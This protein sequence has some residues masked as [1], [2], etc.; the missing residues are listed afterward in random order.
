MKTAVVELQTY[1]DVPTL[2]DKLLWARAPRILLVWP[3]VGRPRLRGPLDFVLLRRYAARLGARLAVVTRDAEVAAWARQARVAVFPDVEAA[4]R[5]AW[6][7]PRRRPRRPARRA[8]PGAGPRARP[9]APGRLTRW[10]AALA[11]VGAVLALLAF[12]LPRAR[13]ELPV[14]AR[15]QQ[16]TLT[17]WARPGGGEGALP[18]QEVQVTVAGEYRRA[19]QGT[20]LWPAQSATGR[21]VFTNLGVDAVDIPAGLRITTVAEPRVTFEVTRGGRVPAGVG[22][23]TTL[24]VRALR[25]GAVGNRPADDLRVLPA[26]WDLRVTVTNPEPTQGGADL[27]VPWP[28][29]DEYAALRRAAETDLRTQAAAR[30]RARGWPWVPA[31]LRVAETVQAVFTPAQPAAAAELYLRL[32]QRYRAWALDPATL[33]AWLTAA[34][35]ARLEPGWQ[36]RAGTLTWTLARAEPA[37]Q[38]EGWAWTVHAVRQVHRSPAPEQVAAW[39]RGRPPRAAQA[40]L[41]ARLALREPPRVQVWPSFWP[42]L[43]WWEA[44]VQVVVVPPAGEGPAGR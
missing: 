3:Q 31:S 6:R 33:R 17:V 36:A 16:A 40:A 21:V 15:P 37:P 14:P 8:K 35:D 9:T 13:V 4:Q 28:E 23:Q 39:V 41:Q 2:Q 43:P 32:E 12:L 22:Q 42:W 18:L 1:D 29:E 24:P 27:A 20:R 10:T 25:P 38:G 34:L 30:L 5:G 11:G 19:V 7:V 44:R 26:G